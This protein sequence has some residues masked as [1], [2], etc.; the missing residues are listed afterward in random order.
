[1]SLNHCSVEI[2]SFIIKS[3]SHFL[4]NYFHDQFSELFS[5]DD[6]GKRNRNDF[7]KFLE[8]DFVQK[9]C[10]CGCVGACVYI[11]SPQVMKNHLR[12]VA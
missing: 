8:I 3:C 1:M 5:T 9:V 12:E 2:I 10:V 7:V 11:Y 4:N 6:S